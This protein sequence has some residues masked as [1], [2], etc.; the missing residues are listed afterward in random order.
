M[1]GWWDVSIVDDDRIINEGELGEATV[2]DGD[3]PGEYVLTCEDLNLLDVV[4]DEDNASAAMVR[5]IQICRERIVDLGEAFGLK[6]EEVDLD[7]DAA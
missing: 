6:V 5:A 4:F 7:V 3:E 1:Q 2:M